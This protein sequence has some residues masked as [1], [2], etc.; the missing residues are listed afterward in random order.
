[1]VKLTFTDEVTPAPKAKDVSL[2]TPKATKAKKS[3]QDAD[4]DGVS[5]GTKAQSSLDK[6]NSDEWRTAVFMVTHKTF[7][8]SIKEAKALLHKLT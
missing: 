2:P 4:L 8:G 3:P 7:R 5:E 6:A 1:M